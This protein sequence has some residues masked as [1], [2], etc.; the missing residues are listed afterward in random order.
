MDLSNGGCWV[1]EQL[2]HPVELVAEPHVSLG[3]LGPSKIFNFFYNLSIFYKYIK[4]I[5]KKKGVG[6]PK[7]SID[8]II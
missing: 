1:V 4:V 8:Q 6:P 7:E 2:E 3:G 5:W